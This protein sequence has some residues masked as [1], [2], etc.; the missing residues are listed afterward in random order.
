M[1]FLSRLLGDLR[2]YRVTNWMASSGDALGT[3]GHFVNEVDQANVITSRMVD[4]AAP[5]SDPFEIRHQ[6]VLDIDHPAQLVESS[7]PGHS[8]LYIQ[9]PGGIPTGHYFKLLEALFDAGVIEKGYLAASSK[10][11]FSC[12]RLPWVSKEST[13][14]LSPQTPSLTEILRGD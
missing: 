6:V 9:V 1:S 5:E 12:V 7:T 11:G 8:H 14:P 13:S 4:P 3:D 2:L 10:R